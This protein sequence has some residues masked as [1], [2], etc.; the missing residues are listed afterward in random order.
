MISA[1][2]YD[3]VYI[4]YLD[5]YTPQLI[6]DT[7]VITSDEYLQVNEENFDIMEAIEKDRI[8]VEEETHVDNLK[9][10]VTN[11]SKLSAQEEG[12]EKS[13]LSKSVGN[14]KAEEGEGVK[15]DEVVEGDNFPEK[16][17]VGEEEV[18]EEEE[19]G[20][21]TEDLNRI[22]V[23][24]DCL[25][26]LANLHP[27]QFNLR[28]WLVEK[29]DECYYLTINP[30]SV[31]E[32]H[33]LLIRGDKMNWNRAFAKEKK[34]EEIEKEMK[35]Y[36]SMTVS[37]G[38]A[39]TKSKVMM[40]YDFSKTHKIRVSGDILREVYEQESDIQNTMS[41]IYSRFYDPYQPFSMQDLTTYLDILK[42]LDA[43]GFYRVVPRTYDDQK[44]FMNFTPHVILR[45][46]FLKAVNQLKN[47]EF[48]VT[49]LE[50][51]QILDNKAEN[52]TSEFDLKQKRDQ[53]QALRLEEQRLVREEE[54]RKQFLIDAKKRREEEERLARLDKDN[55]GG[56]DTRRKGNTVRDTPTSSVK[57]GPSR[58]NT[59]ANPLQ[60][61]DVN[62]PEEDENGEGMVEI[63]KT[64]LAKSEAGNVEKEGAEASPK[65]SNAPSNFGEAVQDMIE[66][67]ME[68]HNPFIKEF[69][70]MSKNIFFQKFIYF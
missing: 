21:T 28:E 23:R 70:R 37:A 10:K 42:D 67:E 1:C 8:Q 27:I 55:T 6:I 4:K 2:N 34:P 13:K 49:E 35:E 31:F 5:R 59:I 53:E 65:F 14:S 7:N 50:F 54:E 18:G 57:G 47:T 25:D 3:K 43:Y 66:E 30:E 69:Y 44:N 26:A 33:S 38:T 15:S 19:K 68:Y 56:Q 24:Q 46:S 12:E 62:I 36:D 11:A 48:N 40:Y 45:E 64:A 60:S 29:F 63:K 9:T 52:L 22:K 51:E 58:Q 41:N 17:G 61:S 20:P 39:A 16:S 32:W